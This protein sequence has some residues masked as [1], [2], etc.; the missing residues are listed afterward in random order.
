[1]W[2]FVLDSVICSQLA[3][4]ADRAVR[5]GGDRVAKKKAAKK[6]KK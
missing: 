1:M 3:C 5:G 2:V 4:R 6:K